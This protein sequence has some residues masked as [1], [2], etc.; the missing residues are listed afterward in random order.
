VTDISIRQPH[1][2][3]EKSAKA[4]AQK[5]ADRMVAEYDISARWNG[6]RL[7]FERSSLSGTLMLHENE[8][9]LEVTLGFL[10][11]AF[12]AKLEEKMVQQMQKVFGAHAQGSRQSSADGHIE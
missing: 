6:N 10:F 8:V 7:N 4:A 2:L 12:S 1:Q 9:R 3:S 5:M 11:K